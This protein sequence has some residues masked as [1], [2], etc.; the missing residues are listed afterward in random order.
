MASTNRIYAMATLVLTSADPERVIR[1]ILE[2][3]T[4]INNVQFVDDL[5]VTIQVRRSSIPLINSIAEKCGASV[6]VKRR[7]GLYWYV[8]AVVRRPVLLIGLISVFAL[9][10]Y[11]S[12]RVLFVE[13]QGNESVP[14]RMILEAASETGIRFGASAREVRSES[15]KNN[16]LSKIPDLQWAGVNTYGSKAV[17]SVR[18]RKEESEEDLLPGVCSIV[19][20]RDGV[21]LS[22][23]VTAGNGMVKPGQ[24]VC[25]GQTLI[26][27]YTDCGL[28]ICATRADGEIVA[29]TRRDLTV[30]TP[31]TQLHRGSI[32]T[33]K[34]KYSL[35][36]GKKRINFYN[37]SGI[38][39]ASCVKM[40]SE[41]V[42]TLPG[43][44]RL[45][46]CLIK[47]TIREY[48]LE[49]SE[50]LDDAMQRELSAYAQRYLRSQMIAGVIT[51]FMEVLS[52]E[53]GFAL[54]GVYECQE[55][56]GRVKPEEIG[57]YHGKTD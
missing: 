9:G 23:T 2:T 46:V 40:Y 37:G 39:D 11:L 54:T 16:L 41:Y 5:T 3:G 30:K 13:V 15:M 55:M 25:A 33:N 20:S 51:N 7:L 22:C 38:S 47:E 10:W 34:T 48:E 4:E 17:I 49:E 53:H 50:G 56:I 32:G 1:R 8:R 18:E 6:S 36:I 27:G 19:A 21:I 26:S 24:A 43:G 29:R 31:L 52:S 45:P 44:F 42:L 35:L 14:T 57:V 28:T 12:G